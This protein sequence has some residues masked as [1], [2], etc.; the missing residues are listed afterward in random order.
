[1]RNFRGTR[2]IQ[3]WRRRM[4]PVTVA[5]AVG[6]LVPALLLAAA[7]A[8][9]AAIPSGISFTQEGC[10]NPGGG[11]LT[12][13]NADGKSISPDA[14]YTTGNLGKNW[15]ELDLVPFRVIVDAGNSA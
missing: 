3:G 10:N 9:N 6:A 8:A 15:A 4:S 2:I 12:L 5:V 7:P 13:R 14:D 11:A 1:M